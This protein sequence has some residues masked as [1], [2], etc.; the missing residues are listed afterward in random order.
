MGYICKL[1]IDGEEQT[2][3]Y[4]SKLL[5]K[6]ITELRGEEIR[7]GLNKKLICVLYYS[8][9]NDCGKLLLESIE[10]STIEDNTDK[11][12]CEYC[13]KYIDMY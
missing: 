10:V 2:F 11:R 4:D 9:C 8:V 1:V 12:I 7:I 5:N 3:E 6:I 13:S